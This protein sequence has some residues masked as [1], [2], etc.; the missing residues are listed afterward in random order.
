MA[1]FLTASLFASFVGVNPAA[2]QLIDTALAESVP[3][4]SVIYMDLDL[5]Q[6]SDQWTQVYALL[7]RSG[8]SD[9]AE[10]E[11]N[12]SPEELGDMAETFEFTGSAALVFTSADALAATGVDEVTD[13]AMGAAVDPAEMTEDIP[14]GMVVLFQPNDPDALYANF[15]QMV[16]DEAESNGAVA[17]S[18]DYNG[19]T[20]DFWTSDDPAVAPTATALVGD[21]V[22]LS[23]RPSDIEPVVDTVN[24]DLDSLATNEDFQMVAGA[25]QADSLSFAYFDAAALGEAALM[26]DPS[27][28]EMAAGYDPGNAG[29]VGWNLYVDESGFRMDTVTITQ[30]GSVPSVLD[31]TMAER[32]PANSLLFVNGTDIAGSGLSELLG[33]VLQ[34]ALA[35]T[36]GSTPEA[37]I[38]SATPT[39]DEV[40]A[41]LE[42]MLGFNVKTDLIDQMDGE[43][44][45]AGNVDQIFSEAPDVDVVFVSE[46]ADEAAVENATS[47]ISFLVG[48]SVDGET[49]DISER[50]VE[51]GTVT[52]VTVEDMI[53]PGTDGVIE[54]AV[55]NGELLF[56]VNDGI[57]T[58]LDGAAA[59][60][61]EEPVYQQTIAALPSTDLVGIQFVNLDRTI[62]MI[63]EAV[64][65]M[66]SSFE[67]LDNDEACGDYATQAE[68]QEAYDADEFELW[69]LDLDYDGEACEDFFNAPASPMASP[70]SMTEDLQILSLGSVS[71][72]EGDMYRSSSILL[73]GE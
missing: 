10:E 11:A 53:S 24:G 50:E 26:S 13:Q 73:I 34:M 69:N 31:P 5:D 54:W 23:V 65:S 39:T 15:Q 2:A 1:F 72:V 58:Y 21:T 46:V 57:D 32:M 40:Y 71:Y 6:S 42:S 8:L 16:A 67:V 27:L 60:L 14:E 17:E 30:D 20:I 64:M 29:S 61:A 49:A 36:D 63:E 28:A 12:T 7:E 48:A 51:G 70:E 18:V 3:A 35:E 59:P 38:A 4:D 22:V 62:P 47:Q 45:I 41:Q 19:T 9:L 33:Y 68:A 37:T 43:W 52:V 25:F 55:I 56:G 44:A 66:E